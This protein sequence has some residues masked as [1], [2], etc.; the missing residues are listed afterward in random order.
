[1]NFDELFPKKSKPLETVKRIE[2]DNLLE[3]MIAITSPP[4][5][6]TAK[7]KQNTEAKLQREILNMLSKHPAVAF[8]MRANSG[9]L[10]M[11]GR[12]IHMSKKGTADIL[13]MLGTGSTAPGMFFALEVKQ[14]GKEPTPVQAAFLQ[15]ITDGGGMALWSDNLDHVRGVFDAL[16]RVGY[17]NI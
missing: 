17:E 15:Q 9:V 13:G 14:P 7:T 1:M 16:V 10:K 12:Y 4:S 6:K 3:Y 11:D 5:P 8:V 2:A